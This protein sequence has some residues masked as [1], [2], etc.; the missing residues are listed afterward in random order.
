MAVREYPSWCCQKCGENVGWI[1]RLV[2]LSH[3]C[4][5]SGN[6]NPEWHPRK[7]APTLPPPP[8]FP[9]MTLQAKW[10]HYYKTGEWLHNPISNRWRG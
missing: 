8:T 3:V 1:G 2:P 6:M 9:P 7:I 5:V 10:D 4:I